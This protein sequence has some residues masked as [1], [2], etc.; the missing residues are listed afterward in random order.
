MPTGST[1]RRRYETDPHSR[2][3]AAVEH[4]DV[5]SGFELLGLVGQGSF[6]EIWKIR[7]S[8]SNR[9]FALKVLSRRWRDDPTARRLLEREARGGSLINC[10][11]T[12]DLYSGFQGVEAGAGSFVVVM[13]AP[14]CHQSGEAPT[15][16]SFTGAPRISNP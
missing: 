3:L 2:S 14:S 10:G 7:E 11:E 5:P 15:L 6:C 1:A 4:V 9:T 12:P 16:L 13:L 8:L